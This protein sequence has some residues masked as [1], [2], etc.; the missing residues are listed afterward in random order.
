MTWEITSYGGVQVDTDF[1]FKEGTDL[2]VTGTFTANSSPQLLVRARA[3]GTWPY[4]TPT[5]GTVMCYVSHETQLD[6]TAIAQIR[7]GDILTEVRFGPV[8]NNR[9]TIAFPMAKGAPFTISFET[10]ASHYEAYF[11]WLPM[12]T[13][14]AP[15]P[16]KTLQSPGEDTTEGDQP[17]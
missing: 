11:Y 4:T 6:G 8:K 7:S 3:Y 1:T 17:C 13:D 2:K 15:Q 14:T 16:V 10:S 12:G 9:A 5:S